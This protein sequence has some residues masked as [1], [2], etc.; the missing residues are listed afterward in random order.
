MAKITAEAYQIGEMWTAF[1]KRYGWTFVDYDLVKQN[2]TFTLK[3][4]EKFKLPLE[5]LDDIQRVHADTNV[6]RLDGTNG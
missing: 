1:G 2:A 4:G 5:V 6:T 3:S